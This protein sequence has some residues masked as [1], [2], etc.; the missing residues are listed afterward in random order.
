MLEDVLPCK[1]TFTVNAIA[2]KASNTSKSKGTW[3]PGVCTYR[4]NTA[5]YHRN[6]GALC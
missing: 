2:V 3:S 5:V 1:T 4:R 6:R